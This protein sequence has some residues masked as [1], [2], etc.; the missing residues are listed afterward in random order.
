LPGANADA[1]KELPMTIARRYVLA[2]LLVL[3][4]PASAQ[5]LE[6]SGT[7]GYSIGGTTVVLSVGRVD[8]ACP[9]GVTGRSG[10]LRLTFWASAT[11]YTGV[12]QPGYMLASHTLG[13]L[14]CNQFFEAISSGTIPFSAPPDGTWYMTIMLEEFDGDYFVVDYLAFDGTETF[15]PPPPPTS[16]TAVEYYHQGFD[17]YF[18]TAI[19]AEMEVLDT[20]QIPGWTRTGQAFRVYPLNAAGAANVCRFF[21]IV[22][23]PRSSHFYTATECATVLRDPVWSFEGEVFA[24]VIPSLSG[25]CP[26][27][28]IALYRLYNEGKSGAPNHRYT[29]NLLLRNDM[30]AQGWTSEGWGPLG[31]IACVPG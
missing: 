14:S 27:G 25:G 4:F 31:V 24:L 2:L 23:A 16:L 6:M 9:V 18:V 1:V 20:R 7:I 8:Y 30:I 13:D 28:T 12:A 15:G 21:T 29:T 5:T 10:T 17:H 11:P 19:T 22:F 3:A 26:F